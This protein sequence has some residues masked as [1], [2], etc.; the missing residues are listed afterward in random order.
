MW[1]RTG[2]KRGSAEA[3]ATAGLRF[4]SCS[5]ARVFI[6]LP[7]VVSVACELPFRVEFGRKGA[8]EAEPEQIKSAPDKNF[9]LTL[10]QCWT[11][12]LASHRELERHVERR[13]SNDRVPENSVETC[14]D[15]LNYAKSTDKT[16]RPFIESTLDFYKALL[17]KNRL[18]NT[19]WLLRQ[20]RRI[21]AEAL[22]TVVYFQAN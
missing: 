5:L 6:L 3:V 13:D 8:Q 17:Q 21:E 7:L 12:W 10:K 16:N 22:Q 14:S 19:S 18:G 15:Y 20:L 11:Y 1:R 2:V 9:N 4:V